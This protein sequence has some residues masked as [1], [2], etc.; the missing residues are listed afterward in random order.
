[1][2]DSENPYFTGSFATSSPRSSAF[3]RYDEIGQSP[4][5]QPAMYRYGDSTI[6]MVVVALIAI[7]ASV[8]FGIILFFA[9]QSSQHKL[10]NVEY[11]GTRCIGQC[12][13][14]QNA[15]KPSK[16]FRPVAELYNHSRRSD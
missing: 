14:S 1:M 2:S 13:T 16:L 5:Q 8:T 3:P 6:L 12:P 7:A 15:E 11:K 9:R 10:E 4:I